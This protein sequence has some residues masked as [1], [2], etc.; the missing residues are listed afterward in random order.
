MYFLIILFVIVLIKLYF[1]LNL[2]ENFLLF[3]PNKTSNQEITKNISEIRQYDA[4]KNYYIEEIYKK[5]EDLENMKNYISTIKS[6]NSTISNEG[7]IMERSNE[8]DKNNLTT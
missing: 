6:E 2:K 1:N 5:F 3:K 4:I 8:K 7:E